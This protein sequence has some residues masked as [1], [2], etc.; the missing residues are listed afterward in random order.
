MPRPI[1]EDKLVAKMTKAFIIPNWYQ[2]H[3]FT[4]SE[5]W[6]KAKVE[7]FKQWFAKSLSAYDPFYAMVSEYMKEFEDDDEPDNLEFCEACGDYMQEFEEC[8]ET[9]KDED[10]SSPPEP[11]CPP[12]CNDNQEDENDEVEEKQSEYMSE[13]IECAKCECSV[14]RIDMAWR[15]YGYLDVCEKCDDCYYNAHPE[16]DDY[17]ASPEPTRLPSQYTDSELVGQ[18][19]DLSNDEYPKF[20]KVVKVT[21]SQVHFILLNSIVK[22][23]NNDGYYETRIYI[24]NPNHTYYSN[25]GVCSPVKKI[26]KKNN[27]DNYEITSEVKNTFYMWN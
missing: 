2:P 26:I 22:S 7:R 5:D 8:E 18:I 23:T 1:N 4:Q 14:K 6:D 15:D 10:Q 16:D 9:K 27:I 17:D 20:C 21:K 11:E 19:F 24:P 13:F 12:P 25:G 3:N